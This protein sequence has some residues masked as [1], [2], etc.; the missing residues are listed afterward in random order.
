MKAI[1]SARFM[2]CILIVATP[3]SARTEMSRPARDAAWS[4]RCTALASDDL[5]SISDAPT[6]II[7][8]NPVEATDK[9]PVHCQVKGYV[10]PQVGFRLGLPPI[11]RWNHKFFEVGCGGD[12]G[13]TGH[14]EMP[15]ACGVPLQRGYACIAF[16]G[17][18]IGGGGLWA[19]NNI[20]AQIDFGYRGAHV[21]ALAGKA[22]TER[23]YDRPPTSCIY[24]QILMQGH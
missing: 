7:A 8:A 2:V 24:P 9:V 10:A 15:R 12:C 13:D 1:S 11:D 6:Q 4:T 3:D 14:F 5:S 16:D 20:Q 22:I 17:G 19:V 18:H 23:Y 21:T